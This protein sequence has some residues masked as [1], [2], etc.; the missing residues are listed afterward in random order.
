MKESIKNITPKI[1]ETKEI[2]ATN[3]NMNTLKDVQKVNLEKIKSPSTN[4]SNC[5]TSAEHIRKENE[6]TSYIRRCF[7]I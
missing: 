2:K 5:A 6:Y 4:L 7:T 1:N 3:R